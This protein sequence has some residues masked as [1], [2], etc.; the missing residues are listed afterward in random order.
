MLPSQVN[1]TADGRQ[2]ALPHAS[3]PAADSAAP[4]QER[5]DSIDSCTFLVGPDSPADGHAPPSMP[6]DSLSTAV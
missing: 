4:S 1:A 3:G 2:A 5:E 6:A